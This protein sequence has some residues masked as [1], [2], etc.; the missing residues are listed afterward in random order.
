MIFQCLA[1]NYLL[2]SYLSDYVLIYSNEELKGK[3]IML[4]K[5]KY[6]KYVWKRHIIIQCTVK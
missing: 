4:Q 5:Y 1:L 6:F 3:E 2:P